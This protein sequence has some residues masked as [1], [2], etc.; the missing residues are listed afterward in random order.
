MV[1]K[2]GKEEER[3]SDENDAGYWVMKSCRNMAFTAFSEQVG[4]HRAMIMAA[5]DDNDHGPMLVRLSG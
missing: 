3:A 5:N 1:T 2:D 4:E